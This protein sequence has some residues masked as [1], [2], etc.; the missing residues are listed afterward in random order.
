MDSSSSSVHGWSGLPFPSSGDLPNPGIEPGSTTL[1]ADSLPFEPLGSPWSAGNFCKSS[2]LLLLLVD[3]GPVIALKWQLHYHDRSSYTK[4]AWST[5]LEPHPLSNVHQ[6]T[7]RSF[8]GSNLDD[9][10]KWTTDLTWSL[11]MQLCWF[12]PTSKDSPDGTGE[13]LG[14]WPVGPS[15]VRL[16]I[17]TGLA[18]VRLTG[19]G[20][21]LDSEVKRDVEGVSEIK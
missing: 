4:K 14:W 2:L 8:L 18:S 17:V 12:L 15:T 21:P 9:F 19:E 13:L 5:P 20:G 1:Q 16:L 3:R 6:I 11:P 7:F 10:L